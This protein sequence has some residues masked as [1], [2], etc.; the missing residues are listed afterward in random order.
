MVA[1][2]ES[3]LRFLRPS[4]KRAPLRAIEQIFCKLRAT[5]DAGR[6]NEIRYACP[7]AGIR[8]A[9]PIHFAE[10]TARWTLWRAI[11]RLLE[12]SHGLDGPNTAALAELG[13]L[14]SQ[15]QV[16]TWNASVAVGDR[17]P[18][19]PSSSS[20]KRE[21][22]FLSATMHDCRCRSMVNWRPAHPC[23][24]ASPSSRRRTRLYRQASV[25]PNIRRSAA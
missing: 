20:P 4:G 17:K 2:G 12:Q 5:E 22:R 8:L 21:S 13:R 16:G 18:Q 3:V 14:R 7:D 15:A 23:S 24:T 6:S 1:P 9:V 25:A 11:R 19:S 10:L